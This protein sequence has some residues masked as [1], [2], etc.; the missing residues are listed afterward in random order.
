MKICRIVYENPPPW[1]G[2]TPHPYE[3]TS[4]QAKKGHNIAVF[5]GR[6]PKSGPLERIRGVDYITVPREPFPGTVSLT[7]S[8]IVFFKYILWRQ[9]NRPDILHCHGHFAIWVYFYRNFLKNFFPWHKELEIPLVV[10]FHNTAKGRWEA[11]EKEGKYIMPHSR[12]IQ[13]PLQV[14]SDQ[15]AVKVAAACI[16]VGKAVME[17][18][19]QFYGANPQRSFLVETGVNTDLFVPVEAPEKERSRK[20]MNLDNF[21]KVILYLGAVVERKNLNL[22]IDAFALLPTTYRLV[23][24]GDGDNVFIQ[25]LYHQMDALQVT[26][27]VHMMGYSPYPFVHIAYQVADV[28]VLPS[29]WEGLPKVVMEALACAIPC[30][31]SGF[32]I[33]EEISGVNYLEN[34]EPQTIANT[35]QKV[36]DARPHVDVQKVRFKYSWEERIKEIDKVYAFAQQNYIL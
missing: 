19:A 21:D 7:S 13:W 20:D 15:L 17:E 35:I 32:K 5:C 11:F 1:D 36:V 6:W 31:V 18:A 3:I 26:D 22:L 9:K 34:L 25:K 27:R 24:L 28:F 29:S 33:Q 30:V 8:V 10:H 16:F 12:Y 4:V 2:L 23:I 14:Y